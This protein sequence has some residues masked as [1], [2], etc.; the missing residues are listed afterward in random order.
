MTL[1]HDTARLWADHH[2]GFT[3]WASDVLAEIGEAFR[4]LSQLQYHQP[5]ADNR[6]PHRTGKTGAGA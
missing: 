4:V 3:R 1:D 5:W 6:D 2:H